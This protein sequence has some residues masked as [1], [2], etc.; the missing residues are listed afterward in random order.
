MAAGRYADFGMR[1]VLVPSRWTIMEWEIYILLKLIDNK[2]HT[3]HELHQA[4]LKLSTEWIPV[5]VYEDKTEHSNPLYLVQV[6]KCIRVN[7]EDCKAGPW[8][9]ISRW[10]GSSVHP[11]VVC[12]GVWGYALPSVRAWVV[13]QGFVTAAPAYKP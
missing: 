9:A 3:Q 4:K 10:C 7:L 1:G 8:Q 12:R 2:Q 5:Q 13:H 6:C 11:H